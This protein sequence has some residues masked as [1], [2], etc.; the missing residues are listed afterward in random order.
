[1]KLSQP[2]F[3]SGEITPLLHVR[4]DLA[5]YATAV[6]SL[7]NFIVLPEGGIARRSGFRKPRPPMSKRLS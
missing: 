1:M 5:W 4:V 2:S 7:V 6:K 3:T